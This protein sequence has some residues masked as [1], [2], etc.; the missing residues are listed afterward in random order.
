MRERDITFSIVGCGR[1]AERHAEHIARVGRLVSVCDTNIERAK[2]FS[3]KYGAVA[4]ASLAEMLSGPECAEVIS[5]CSPN[6]L[7]A[8]HSIL[9][10]R[11]GRHVVCEKPMALTVRDCERMIMES[12]KAG[13]RLFIVKQNR[14]NPPIVELKRLISDGALGDIL[15]VQLNCFWNR[16]KDYYGSSEWKGTKDLDG[17]ALYTQFSHFLDLLNWLIGDVKELRAYTGNANHPEIEIDDQGV[18]A[19]RFENEALGTIH[20]STNAFEK[21]LEGSLTVFGT[22][23]T[24]KVGG[25]YL[26]VLEYVAVEDYSPPTLPRGKESNDYGSYRG[27]MSNHDKVYENVADVLRSSGVITTSGIEGLR[28]VELICRIY[29]AGS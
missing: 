29:D 22:R 20:Y 6:G 27:S 2:E 1:I 12:E 19:L 13:R 11:A 15:S 10:L 7:H 26:N 18:V 5:V 23:G 24:V 21:N 25:E 14:F 8:E 28:T 4:Y 3:R 16:N 17:G 9:S